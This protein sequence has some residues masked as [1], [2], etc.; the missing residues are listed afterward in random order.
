MKGRRIQLVLLVVAVL[1][2][3]WLLPISG[4]VVVFPGDAE[5]GLWPHFVV[6]QAEAGATATVKVIDVEPWTFVQLLVASVPAEPQGEAVESAGTWTWTWTYV[7]PS[8]R[9]YDL[10]FYRDC[11][12]GCVERGRT[13]LGVPE[14]LERGGTAT[15]L[16]IVM[17][18][19]DR[20]WHGRSGWAVEITY[21]LRSDDPYWGIDD[22]A[23]RVAAHCAKGLRV[24]VRVDYE[25]R[26]SLPPT[27]DYV[28]L[29]QYLAYFRRLARDDRLQGVYGYIVGSDFNTFDAAMLMPDSP[30]TPAWYARVFSGYGE[31]PLHSDNVVQVV[32]SE[33]PSVR[34]I[35]GPLRPWAQDRIAVEGANSAAPWLDYMHAV[36][37][38]LDA[39]ATAKA[40]VGVAAAGPDGFDV[41]AP[42]SPDVPEMAGHLRAD[43]PYTDL[44]RAAW[45]NAQAGFRVYK[46][47][48]EVINAYPTTRGMPVYVVSTNT[49]DRGAGIP[50]A[51]NYPKGWLTAALDV[52]N[53]EP[54]I[55]A[56]V[57][58]L[59]DF[60]H[61]D[62]WDWFSLTEQPGRLVDAAEEF[63]LLLR[64]P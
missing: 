29:A 25:Q 24:L 47:W 48:L 34:V 27:D 28:A 26:Q 8:A 22:L 49:Y 2:G 5:A 44:P 31:E 45:G 6:E 32:R 56:L 35:A 20:D 11:H 18:R 7:V 58:F 1:A 21:A 52:I 41:Q 39:S 61:S 36:V 46:D 23:R 53:S 16:G 51:Q 43:E 50:P 37:A 12:T 13:S 17:P 55:Q 19:L 60:P 15:K 30:I 57:W 42:G 33:N 4:R 9:G 59:D 64:S 63:D 3:Y 62:E 40:A 54:Q 10:S 38:M 14:S